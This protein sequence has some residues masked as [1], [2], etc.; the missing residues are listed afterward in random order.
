M[1]LSKIDTP[2]PTRCAMHGHLGV[3]FFLVYPLSPVLTFYPPPFGDFPSRQTRA[4]F[5][6]YTSAIDRLK[7]VYIYFIIIIRLLLGKFIRSRRKKITG[8]FFF[9]PFGNSKTVGFYLLI[10]VY[11]I[12]SRLFL[13][14]FRTD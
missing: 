14:L 12:V 3:F 7:I 10:I 13:P 2:R 1:D 6:T 11:M 4:R 5:T 8:G 9:V